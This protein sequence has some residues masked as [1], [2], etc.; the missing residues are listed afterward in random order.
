MRA[1]WNR[2]PESAMGTRRQFAGCQGD[3]GRD[4]AS[5]APLC[6]TPPAAREEEVVPASSCAHLSSR[7]PLPWIRE[8]AAGLQRLFTRVETLREQ[9]WPLNKALRRRWHGPRF[10]TAHRVRVRHG[11]ASLRARYYHWRR[12]GRTPECL[13]LRFSSTLPPVPPE[14]VRAFVD[15]CAVAGVTHF[16]QAIRLTMADSPSR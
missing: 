6:T 9:G 3:S 1:R 14:I 4:Y 10:H 12:S 16:S 11:L 5:R 2:T 8:E 7:F 15:A 13:A